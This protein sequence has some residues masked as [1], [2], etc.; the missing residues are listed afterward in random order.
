MKR[1]SPLCQENFHFPASF[2]L[3]FSLSA[4]DT[5]GAQ[6]SN[7]KPSNQ[8]PSHQTRAV[9]VGISNYQDPGIPDLKYA[10]RDAEAFANWLCSPAGGSL[11]ND[12]LL[13]LTNQNATAGRVAEALDALIE[14]TKEGELVIIYFSGHGDVERKTFSQPGFLLCWDSP[15]RVYMG[16]GT[17]SLAFLQEIVTTLSTQNKAKVVVVIDACHAGKL[18][19]SQIGGTQLTAASMAKQFANEV[20]ILSCQPG[21]LSLEGEQWGGGR[22]I[23]SYHLV[24][25]L[26]GLADK[27]ADG[28]V[29]LSELDRYLED[30]VTAEVSPQ[31]QVPMLLGNKTERLALINPQILAEL[32]KAKAGGL[33]VFAATEARGLETEV[34]A[35]LDS[36]MVKRYF[37]FK[38]AV[39]E[40][41]FFEPA[42]Y[43][44]EGLYAVLSTEPGLAPLHGFMKR[45]YAA[46]LQNEAQQIINQL[47]TTDPQVLDDAFSPVAR[48]DHLPAY[49][50]RAAE[51]LG[52]QHYMWRFLKARE[53][54]FHS[55]TLRQDNH[56]N[57]PVDTLICRQI[58][59]LDTALTYDPEAA[60]LYF[61]KGHMQM[62]RYG[63][64]N[65]DSCKSNLE[66][67]VALAPEWV[68]PRYFLGYTLLWSGDI[69]TGMNVLHESLKMDSTYLPIYRLLGTASSGRKQKAVWLEQYVRRMQEFEQKNPGRVPLVYISSLGLAL[70]QLGKNE[71]A[72][73]VLLKGMGLS[74]TFSHF[75]ANLGVVYIDLGQYEEAEQA[76]LRLIE[77]SPLRTEGY[78]QLLTNRLHF[79][80]RNLETVPGLCRQVIELGLPEEY[81]SLIFYYL[82]QGR[83]DSAFS[84]TREWLAIDSTNPQALLRLGQIYLIQGK[85]SEAQEPFQ[86][87]LENKSG[88]GEDAISVLYYQIVAR[89]QT[90]KPEDVQAFIEGRRPPDRRP[91]G[92]LVLGGLCLCVFQ[93]IRRC[94]G[95]A[96]KIFAGRLETGAC[97]V[98]LSNFVQPRLRRHPAH[99][100][101]PTIGEAVFAGAGEGI[102]HR[103]II[104]CRRNG[105]LGRKG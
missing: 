72:R 33:P 61:E 30:H 90:G 5:R 76:A 23:F 80:K 86:N 70:W 95:V 55:K 13:V 103:K 29:T 75:Y 88:F 74:P 40:K 102:G 100:K 3:T 45:N 21:E 51:L 49:L 60:Y 71:D 87:L 89:I 1:N 84:A 28:Q 101:I 38:K 68:L 20:K 62:F 79:L 54:F 97:S 18:A 17:Y 4:Q 34:L 85:V 2:L 41:R 99:Q 31:S 67:A 25:G 65:F 27:N 22:G 46:A 47:L 15:A 59:C 9:V 16:G 93:P 44:A 43:C 37:V 42:D 6:P 66:R 63:L 96:G 32:K 8:K 39:E 53:Y 48:Y 92:R 94:T 52:E 73:A 14:Q 56:P 11:D 12:H 91:F 19:G 10:H 36:G 78:V 35:K 58:A 7:Q 24:D 69:A 50:A 104:S 77:L 81:E 26:F 98:G 64:I 57:L 82:Q 83:I 105:N